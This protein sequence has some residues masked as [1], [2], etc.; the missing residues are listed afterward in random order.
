MSSEGDPTAVKGK[1]PPVGSTLASAPGYP[2]FM[3]RKKQPPERRHIG[4]WAM[5][6]SWLAGGGPGG[7][8]GS[9]GSAGEEA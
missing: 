8:R 3:H 1:A 2:L 9:R 6:M 7:P 4:L 5:E